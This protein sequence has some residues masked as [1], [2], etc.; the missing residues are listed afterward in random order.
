MQNMKQNNE[1]YLGCVFGLG[2]TAYGY[3]HP[4]EEFEFS[5]ERSN[6]QND[7]SFQSE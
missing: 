4:I 1:S 6:E 3:T 2:S 5:D 7:N